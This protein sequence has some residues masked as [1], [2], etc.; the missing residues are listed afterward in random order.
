MSVRGARTV[1]FSGPMDASPEAWRRLATLG[2]AL[3]AAPDWAEGNDGAA[4]ELVYLA[5]DGASEQDAADAQSRLMVEGLALVE[6]LGWRQRSSGVTLAGEADLRV[7][8]RRS[9]GAE[10]LRT[11]A[12]PQR[13]EEVQLA[14]IAELF[15]L[16]V[17][18]LDFVEPPD[19]WELPE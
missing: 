13:S 3:Q 5:P 15:G 1:V 19:L 10:L 12:S 16:D 11:W 6:P 9:D 4:I 17:S 8:R 2:V 14:T 7:V 18:D